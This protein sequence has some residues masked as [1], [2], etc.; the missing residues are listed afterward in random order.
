MSASVNRKKSGAGAMLR[1]SSIPCCIAH[2]LPDQPPGSGLTRDDRKLFRLPGGLGGVT[3]DL[4][5]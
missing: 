2:S 1:A 4:G 3:R 5:G